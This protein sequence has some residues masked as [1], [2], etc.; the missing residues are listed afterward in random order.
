MNILI[1]GGTT[2][3]SAIARALGVRVVMVQRP[4]APHGTVPDAASALAWLHHGAAG[5]W[6]RG[7]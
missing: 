5:G 1:L 2:Q 6:D 7:A 3:A 4:P